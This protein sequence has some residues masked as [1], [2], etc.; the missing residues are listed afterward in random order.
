[1]IADAPAT[2]Q[3]DGLL[4]A[5]D[6]KGIA[7]HLARDGSPRAKPPEGMPLDSETRG[8]LTANRDAL[9]AYLRLDGTERRLRLTAAFAATLW[10]LG[11]QVQALAAERGWEDA[12]VV[13][14]KA[15][16]LMGLRRL[17][18]LYGGAEA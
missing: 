6:L 3:L 10:P 14:M 11:K 18:E 4:V 2:D 7:L 16:W 9:L 8:L 15:G 17:E 12:E 5:L 13:A 1:M